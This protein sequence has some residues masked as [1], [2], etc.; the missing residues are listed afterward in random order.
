MTSN[1]A[2][3]YWHKVTG[4]SVYTES[5]PRKWDC[6][7][8][9]IYTS[10]N[11]VKCSSDLPALTFIKTGDLS[12]VSRFI[13]KRSIL[14]TPLQWKEAWNGLQNSLVF[15]LGIWNARM[16]AANCSAPLHSV[17]FFSCSRFI[18][19]VLKINFEDGTLFRI[20]SQKL[21]EV[22]KFYICCLENMKSHKG[23]LNFL[24]SVIQTTLCILV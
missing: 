6:S 23:E 7:A 14:G 22:S 12:L 21:T 13:P 18:A 15:N 17:V 11:S 10:W 4:Q 1:K 9:K 24:L 3:K 2:L 5:V 16:V 8:N 20:V 19:G